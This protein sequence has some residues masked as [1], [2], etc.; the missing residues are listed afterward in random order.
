MILRAAL[1]IFPDAD[2]TFA[3]LPALLPIAGASA[4]GRWRVGA[5]FTL[6]YIGSSAIGET[7]GTPAQTPRQVLLATCGWAFAVALVWLATFGFHLLNRALTKKYGALA[8]EQRRTI[9][10]QL[11]DTAARS[12]GRISLIAESAAVTH[13]TDDPHILR[14]VAALARDA[15]ADLDAMLVALRTQETDLV[16]AFHERFTIQEAFQAAARSLI[17]QGFSPV[18]LNSSTHASLRPEIHEC[19]VA[20]IRESSRNIAKHGA[21]GPCTLRLAASQDHGSLVLTSTNQIGRHRSGAGVGGHG[22]TGLGERLAILNG[23]LVSGRSPENP[24]LWLTSVTLPL[25]EDDHV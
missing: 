20:A 5:V 9:A 2:S 21:Q 8:D 23:R 22:L 3:C 24:D 14:H 17:D 11:H 12:L 16:A 25:K 18:V 4:L 15:S 19:L 1:L 7:Q 6:L 10:R 13:D